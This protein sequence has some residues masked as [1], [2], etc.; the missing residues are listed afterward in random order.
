MVLLPTP[1]HTPGSMSMLVRSE[2]LPPILLAGDLAYRADF[3]LEN[4]VPGT[5]DPK[6]LRQ[7]YAN[8]RQLKDQLPELLIV[9]T[10]DDNAARELEAGFGD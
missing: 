10:H 4:Q 2:N 5:G 7:T 3:I 9:P 6:Q 8:V 1:G